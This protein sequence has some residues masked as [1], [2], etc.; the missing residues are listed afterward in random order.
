MFNNKVSKTKQPFL[1]SS[2]TLKSNFIYHLNS[3]EKILNDNS[4]QYDKILL[5][6][7]TWGT[8]EKHMERFCNIYQLKTL[9]Y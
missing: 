9:F 4:A 6:E 2:H 8:T 1:S 7:L 3:L 5:I